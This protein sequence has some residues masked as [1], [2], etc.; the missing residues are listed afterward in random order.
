MDV[1][2][3]GG[4]G[5]DSRRGVVRERWSPGAAASA[6]ERRTRAEE[7]TRREFGFIDVV[8]GGGNDGNDGS[9]VGGSG[10]DGG[11][12][13]TGRRRRFRPGGDDGFMWVRGGTERIQMVGIVLT[14]RVVVTSSRTIRT[15]ERCG[16][17]APSRADG[18]CSSSLG[19]LRRVGF[20]ANYLLQQ[21]L[22]NT[23]QTDMEST[24]DGGLVSKLM[25]NEREAQMIKSG[26]YSKNSRVITRRRTETQISFNPKPRMSPSSGRTRKSRKSSS[27]PARRW[28]RA[29]GR[30]VT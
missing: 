17:C 11:W 24:N 25:N 28:R 16:C 12:G 4:D 10:G 27:N 7:Q 8:T 15:W 13:T 1:A 22:A 21:Y 29:Q 26:R 3:G 19:R 2:H 9:G 20:V 14:V 5:D 6:S 23:L 30:C 18:A